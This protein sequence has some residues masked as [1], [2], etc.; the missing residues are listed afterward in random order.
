MDLHFV[1][2]KQRVREQPGMVDKDNAEK[3]SK[4]LLLREAL[5]SVDILMAQLY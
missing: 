5:K 4:S 3:G 2:V 1:R